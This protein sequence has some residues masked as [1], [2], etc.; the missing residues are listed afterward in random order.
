M[1]T[2][3]C[4][5]CTVALLCQ[6]RAY[7]NYLQ[8]RYDWSLARTTRVY[9]LNLL[10]ATPA[11][12]ADELIRHTR[13]LRRL[14]ARFTRLLAAAAEPARQEQLQIYNEIAPGAQK[15]VDNLIAEAG[16][17]L[18]EKDNTTE[19]TSRPSTLHTLC[20]VLQLCLRLPY[21]VYDL[22]N[23]PR[24]DP[25]HQ[26]AADAER[27]LAEPTHVGHH[28]MT[29]QAIEYVYEHVPDSE[30]P[31]LHKD[32]PKYLITMPNISLDQMKFI[33]ES[34]RTMVRARDT[35]T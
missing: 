35:H 9:E 4:P 15:I 34:I 31:D 24:E 13:Y 11:E 22:T 25:V 21:V 18:Y 32:A 12:R 28:G 16:R 23:N 8:Q 14:K 7:F 29:I 33:N 1:L 3:V 5:V 27:R 26:L 19:A 30:G 6:A 2:A 20:H 10:D 17:R